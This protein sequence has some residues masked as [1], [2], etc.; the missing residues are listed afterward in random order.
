MCIQTGRRWAGGRWGGD[1]WGRDRWGGWGRQPWREI[2][3]VT[4]EKWNG[5][6]TFLHTLTF[7]F[8]PHNCG[9][10]FKNIRIDFFSVLGW[11]R[12]IRVNIPTQI[13]HSF[14]T[15]SGLIVV[16]LTTGLNLYFM[17]QLS[18]CACYWQW[19][20]SIKWI[21]WLVHLFKWWCSKGSTSI[22]NG[23]VS[24]Q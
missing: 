23:S 13:L 8:I 22:S 24:E 1:R 9:G 20:L 5:E 7:Y 14:P 11:K 21:V 4:Q 3:G 2:L 15:I 16:S 6:S 18:L 10:H 12:D 17:S 19:G